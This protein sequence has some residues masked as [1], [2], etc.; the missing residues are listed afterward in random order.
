MLRLII[1]AAVLYILYRILKGMFL[2]KKR[3][4][5][6]SGGEIVDELVQDPECKLYIPSK[7]SVKRVIHG[8]RH[9]FCSEECAK[10]YQEKQ[11]K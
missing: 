6:G 11:E 1:I 7:S 9:S 2:Q 10:R 8:R 4:V 5:R 3:E